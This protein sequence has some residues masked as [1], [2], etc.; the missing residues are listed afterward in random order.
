MGKFQIKMWIKSGQPKD[1]HC[2][3][4]YEGGNAGAD[5]ISTTGK[6]N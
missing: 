5:F 3:I 6:K 4:V 1:A 2:N